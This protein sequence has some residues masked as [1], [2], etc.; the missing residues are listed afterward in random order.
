M[1]IYFLDLFLR[2]FS[3]Q[4]VT[5]SQFLAHFL[6]HVNGRLQLAQIFSGR[7][8]LFP[9]WGTVCVLGVMVFCRMMC[10]QTESAYRDGA[11]S[12]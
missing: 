7:Y 2:H 11:A 10:F 6:R 9:L 8:D 3:L 1:K 4:Y 5:E 12:G